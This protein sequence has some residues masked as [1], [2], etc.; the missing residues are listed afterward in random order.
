MTGEKLSA[1]KHDILDCF[2]ARGPMTDEELCDI[3]M[4]AHPGDSTLRKRRGEL[5]DAGYII[6]SAQRKLN[7]G[8]HKMVVW[9]LKGET[10]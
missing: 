3:L 6:D 4:E 9:M 8:G 10:E 5:R 1:I 7:R 2:M